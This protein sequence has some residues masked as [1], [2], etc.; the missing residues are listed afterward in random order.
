MA[1]PAPL[2]VLPIPQQEDHP[3]NNNNGVNRRHHS[4]PLPPPTTEG[5]VVSSLNHHSHLQ[6][7]K[8]EY[9]RKSMPWKT[10]RILE[11]FSMLPATT[12]PPQQPQPTTTIIIIGHCLQWVGELHHNPLHHR[13][14]QLDPHNSLAAKASG[15]NNLNNNPEAHHPLNPSAHK[16]NHLN[17]NN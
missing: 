15:L 8:T 11:I 14:V 9:R 17:H 2:A 7:N 4:G 10:S 12:Q 6:H 13:G 5:G 3:H 16:R 1:R